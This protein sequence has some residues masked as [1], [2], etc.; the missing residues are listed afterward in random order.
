MQFCIKSFITY[1]IIFSTLLTVIHIDV[2]DHEK[3][4]GYS[5]CDVECNE[6]HHH[7]NN[8]Q[9]EICINNN[10]TIILVNVGSKISYKYFSHIITKFEY[11]KKSYLVSNLLSRPPPAPTYT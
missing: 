2:H 1:G 5:F 6:R 3:H 8:H 4:D 11:Q 10:S 9:C 7:L